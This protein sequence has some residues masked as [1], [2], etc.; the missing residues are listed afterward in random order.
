MSENTSE[1]PQH[2]HFWGGHSTNTTEGA[3]ARTLLRGPQHEH[4]WG[5]HSTNTTEGATARTLLRGPQHEHYWGG[6][7]TNTSEGA[8]ARTLLRGHSTNTTEGATARTLLRGHSTNTSE[9]PQHE[10]FPVLVALERAMH[11]PQISR[12]AKCLSMPTKEAQYATVCQQ[13]RHSMPTK[14]AQYATVCQQKRHSM[15]QCANKRGTV[16]QQRWVGYAE[17]RPIRSLRYDKRGL[18]GLCFK[19]MYMWE[20]K[21][22]MKILL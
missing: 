4:F 16:C 12:Y 5:G 18:I 8:T 13:K 17:I 20:R 9:G 3:T 7:S 6:H 15:P 11:A 21:K 10:H 14:E 2:E 1:G 19:F 22:V